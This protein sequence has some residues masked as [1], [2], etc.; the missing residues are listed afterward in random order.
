M[1]KPER[2]ELR[3]D[4]ALLARVDRWTSEREDKPSRSEALRQLAEI[5][6]GVASGQAVHFSPGEKLNF[7]LLRDLVKGLGV[8]TETD[9]DFMAAAMHGGHYWAPTWNM[10]GL[11]HQH[12]DRPSDVSFVVSVLDMWTFLEAGF[13]KL[14]PAER[15]EVLAKNFDA[16]VNFPGFDGNS[17]TTLLAIARFLIDQMGR[18]SGFKGRDLDSH[19]PCA[20][21]YQ[22]MLTLFEPMRADLDGRPMSTGELL[23]LL[24]ARKNRFS[25][26]VLKLVQLDPKP[27]RRWSS[28][29]RRGMSA[30]APEEDESPYLWFVDG[31]DT[32]TRQLKIRNITTGHELQ[33]K[34]ADVID[35][36]PIDGAGINDPK[37]RLSLRRQL[38]FVEGLLKDLPL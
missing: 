36:T 34:G 31:Y 3:V 20:D 8:K 4:E 26:V 16:P 2:I 6:L 19:S 38:V 37:F 17:E 35:V 9:V 10:Q 23:Q 22:R 7:M 25:H 30:G 1:G 12:A 21:G 32:K 5:G 28:D 27:K 14:S 33:I 18:F 15:D 13:K 24:E 29:T 11:F